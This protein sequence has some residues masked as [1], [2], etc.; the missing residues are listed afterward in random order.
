MNSI[1]KK[2][3]IILSV[4]LAITCLGLGFVVHYTSARAL[5]EMAEE[6]TVK[7]AM[8]SA[9]VVEERIN[10]SFRELLAIA[11]TEKIVS[12]DISIDEKIEYVRQ[13]AARAGYMSLGIG[14]TNGKTLTMDKIE[15]DLKDRTYYQ[16]ALKGIP[17]VTDPII[18]REDNTS[19]IVNYAVPITEKDG[20]VIGVLIGARDGDELSRITDD[21]VLGETG[22][23]FMVNSEGVSVAHYDR[24]EVRN[25]VNMTKKADEDESLRELS[26]AGKII[27]SQDSG[28][29]EYTYNNVERYVA[30]AK[31]NGTDWTIAI[32]VPKLEILSSLS[33]LRTRSIFTSIGFLIVSL[34]FVYIIANR[35]AKDIGNMS[36]SLKVIANGDFTTDR[37][38]VIK[39]KDEI[40]DAYRSMEIMRESISNM[41]RGIKKAALIVQQDSANLSMI[42][43]GMASASENVSIATQD[44]AQGIASQAEGLSNINMALDS[45]GEK[46]EGIVKDIEDMDKASSEVERMSEKGS[47]DMELLMKSVDIIEKSF[48]DFTEKINGFNQN[49]LQITDITNVINGIA[50]QTNLLALN[51][52]IEAARAGEVGRGFAVVAEEIRKLA[53]QSQESSQNINNLINDITNDGDAILETTNEL[54]EELEKE[55]NI[56]NMTIENYKDIVNS[57]HNMTNRIEII[58]ELAIDIDNDKN[59]ILSNVSDASAVAEEVSASSEEIAASSEEIT[60]SS[61]EVS[62]SAQN[63]DSLINNMLD[64]VNKFKIE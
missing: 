42:A 2:F 49:I 22:K 35:L 7:T 64:E 11:N 18:N 40:A 47:S 56:I 20:T 16:N 3:T 53:E 12:R 41:I 54:N 43:E 60:A 13:E 34:G 30:F 46:L 8:E 57:I 5:E 9:K 17:T 59:Q 63:L 58:N 26:E 62:S 1:K 15:I 52:A 21:I 36:N 50:E 39:G 48:K 33:L 6:L 19:L 45:F 51:A 4:L 10:T 29:V 24:D 38:D 25:A 28:F 32:E 14:D 55:I 61:E 27:I 23:A 37:S 44:T 31:V